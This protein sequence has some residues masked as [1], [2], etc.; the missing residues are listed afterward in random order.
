MLFSCI[1]RRLC[2][3]GSEYLF[4]NYRYLLSWQDADNNNIL[5]LLGNYPG[6]YYLVDWM[7]CHHVERLTHALMSCNTFNATPLHRALTLKQSSYFALL[8]RIIHQN[9]A[10]SHNVLSTLTSKGQSLLHLAIYYESPHL[11]AL[12]QMYAKEAL[13]HIFV[14]SDINHITP[15]HTLVTRYKP[16]YAAT[17]SLILKDT[18]SFSMAIIDHY[19]NNTMHLLLNQC[20]SHPALIPLTIRSLKRLI[21]IKPAFSHNTVTGDNCNDC[22]FRYTNYAGQTLLHIACYT[23]QPLLINTLIDIMQYDF[24]YLSQQ[25]NDGHNALSILFGSDID[26]LYPLTL[27]LTMRGP[28]TGIH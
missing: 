16:C 17:L 18:D 4:L 23:G 8:V 22:F 14:I 1:A 9:A 13:S 19:G 10:H 28:H 25:D 21:G 15:L 20:A 26:E 3:L 7:E 11:D 24:A 2:C 27:R 5:H 6:L 12:I